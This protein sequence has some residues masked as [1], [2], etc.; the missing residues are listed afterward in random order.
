MAE[1]NDFLNDPRSVELARR[2]AR[3]ERRME[4][5][6][7]RRRQLVIRRRIIF[8]SVCALI[9]FAVIFFAVRPIV[10][11]AV[12]AAKNDTE[13][14]TLP[15]DV[16]TYEG[17]EPA[18]SLDETEYA[19]AGYGDTAEEADPVVQDVF[20]YYVSGN[21]QYLGL[22]EVQSSYAVLIDADTGEVL[23]Q[24]DAEAVVSPASMTKIL[25][26][27][28]A[29]EHITDLDDTFVMTEEITNYSYSHGCSNVGFMPGEVITVRDM[30]YGTILESGADAALGLANY[31][32]GSQEA[33]VE[34]MNEKLAQFGLSGTAHFTN[35]VG[36]FDD[37]HHCTMC[38]MAVI[39]A[40]A[41]KDPLCCEVLNR[42]TYTTSQTPDH[43]EGIEIS[44]WFLRRIEDKDCHGE[45]MYAKTGF[46][47]ESGCCAASY[48]V[49]NSGRHYLCVTGNAWS[50]WRCIYDHVAIY[51][52]YTG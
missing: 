23:Y 11:K 12:E 52:A 15:D 48:Q 39:L 9:L 45:V 49:S 21:T 35:C 50:A 1:N 31:I 42:R 10:K 43:P 8:G 14:E 26:L 41:I 36:I 20:H 51:A 28:V 18:Q 3:A 25:T 47:N 37:D 5:Y 32:S 4:L 29:C 13:A 30:L 17:F 38:D 40:Q 44:N 27:L 19:E 46:V 24:R 34:L 2:R 6:N 7:R 16:Q 33:F 22:D